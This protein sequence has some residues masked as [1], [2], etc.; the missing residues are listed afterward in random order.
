MANA[1]DCIVAGSCVVDMLCRPVNLDKPIGHGLLYPCDPIVITGG[2]VC[3][4]SGITMA[5]LGVKVGVFTYLGDDDWAPVVRNLYEKEGI[6]TSPLLTHPTE[7]TSTTVVAIDPS[8]ERSFWHCVGAPL[9]M[10]ARTFYDHMDF[11]AN[12]RMLLLGYYS[13]MT[14][15][16][17][18]LAQVFAKLRAAGCRT[19]LD[20]AGD[21]GSMQP[22]DQILLQTDVYVPSRAEAELQTGLGDP[23]K[24]IDVFRDCGAPGVVGV[25]LGGDGVILSDA[26]GKYVEIGICA[27]PGELV[28]TTGAGDSFF[29][30]LVTGLLK[31]MPLENAGKLGNAA[32]ACCCTAVGG[33]TGGRGYEQTAGI[34]G[35]V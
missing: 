4:N 30:G 19:A 2:G 12:C 28:D 16:E 11:F 22:L 18:D 26:P 5:R 15:L 10:N 7:A 3:S 25:K 32:A 9:T 6:D 1:L 13:L 33:S 35:L 27:P 23:Q 17:P 31:G 8:G 24:M 21:G 29:A 20:A 34:A 14:N